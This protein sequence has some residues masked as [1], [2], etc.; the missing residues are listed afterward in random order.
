M[1]RTNANALGTTRSTSDLKHLTSNFPLP[2]LKLSRYPRFF[3][4]TSQLYL[5]SRKTHF[6]D[7]SDG[8]DGS[9]F[10]GRRRGFVSNELAQERNQH[11]ERDTDRESDESKL[12]EKFR[13]TGVGGDRCRTGR[14]RYHS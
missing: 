7:S 14:V 3:T 5:L 6:L 9:R 4:A 2:V 1:A 11:D 12:S 13:I 10:D 8:N